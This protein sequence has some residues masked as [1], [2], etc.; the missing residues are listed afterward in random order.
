MGRRSQAVRGAAGGSPARA[1]PARHGRIRCAGC[2][3]HR[4]PIQRLPPSTSAGA[5]GSSG[6]AERDTT[7][8]RGPCR[9]RSV[10]SCVPTSHP[11][12]EAR[13]ASTYSLA[14]S[15][16]AVSA[17]PLAGGPTVSPIAVQVAPSSLV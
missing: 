14:R 2:R 9:N 13:S 11:P 3:P 7:Q 15:G 1:L 8:P 17:G 16:S 12:A 10:P 4:V 5:P 6:V